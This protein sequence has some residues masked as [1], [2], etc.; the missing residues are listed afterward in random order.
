MLPVLE[1]AGGTLRIKNAPPLMFV[2]IVGKLPA[3]R[4][5]FNVITMINAIVIDV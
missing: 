2:L 3:S 4:W 1:S 5:W